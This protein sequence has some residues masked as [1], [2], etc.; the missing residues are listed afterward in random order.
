MLL[1]PQQIADTL[2][3]FRKEQEQ[4]IAQVTSW[5]RAVVKGGG[6][7]FRDPEAVTQ[8]ILMT[9]VTLVRKGRVEHPEGFLKYARTVAKRTCLDTYY[10][11]QRT[12]QH[13]S[14]SPEGFDPA[15]PSDP[16]HGSFEQRERLAA[17]KYLVQK[18]SDDCRQLWRLIYIEKLS[19]ELVAERLGLSAINVRVRAHR[20]LEKARTV[21][22]EFQRHSPG[23]VRA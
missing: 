8:E 6:W 22:D 3:A 13:E 20:C 7:G 10:R 12:Q 17:L 4:G 21:I 2:E 11:Q 15:D 16:T 18:L 19:S 1:S 14:T 5:V 9:L 23:Q